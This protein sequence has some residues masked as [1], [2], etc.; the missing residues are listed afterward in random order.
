M[1]QMLLGLL[2]LAATVPVAA[3][4]ESTVLDLYSTPPGALVAL[5][6]R[7]L[8]RTPIRLSPIVPGEH[9]LRLSAG[10][11]YKP[12][13]VTVHV[14]PGVV[15]RLDVELEPLPPLLLRQGIEAA[16]AGRDA[17][18]LPLLRKATAQPEAWWW[19]GVVEMR[20][21]RD[22]PALEAFRR[23]ASFHPDQPQVYLRLGALHER[24]GDARQAV[25]A[26]KLALLRSDGL[27]GALRGVPARPTWAEIAAAGTPATP[28]GQLRLAWMYE[29]KGRMDEALRWLR[30]AVGQV[31]PTTGRGRS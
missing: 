6:H 14:E 8:G 30:A 24:A 13:L 12:F 22:G 4:S 3:Q 17:E 7:V 10:A 26:Y 11:D 2:L 15:Q 21:R 16:E 31:F 29:Q 23:Y 27:R 25:T 20:A 1:R 5:D 18:A 9:E 19:I 28:E